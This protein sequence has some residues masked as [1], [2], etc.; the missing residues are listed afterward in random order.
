MTKNVMMALLAAGAGALTACSGADTPTAIE[1]AGLRPRLALNAVTTSAPVAG[2]VKVC[3]TGNAGGTFTVTRTAVGASTGTVQNPA[4]VAAGECRVVAED[5]GGS[6]IGSNV[7]VLETSAGFVSASYTR[8]DAAGTTNYVNGTT[9]V[10]VNSIH[11]ITITFVNNVQPPVVRGCTYTQGWYKN[12]GAGTLPTG[13]FFLSGQTRL[14]V[15]DTPPKGGNEYYQLA[16]QYIAAVQNRLSASG[17]V[18]VDA[19]IAAAT[20]YFGVATPTN[21]LPGSYTNAQVLGW[22]TTLDNYNNG[23]I[24]PGHCDD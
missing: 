20:T 15:L 16:H 2:Q 4:T 18:A 24:G 5:A 23:I 3:K 14:Q 17:T 19:A 8:N 1:S 21:T 11:G 13:N 7:K 9:E 10:F 22:A 6:N 12:K